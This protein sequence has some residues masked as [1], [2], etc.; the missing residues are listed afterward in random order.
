MGFHDIRQTFHGVGLTWD[1]AGESRGKSRGKHG[2]PWHL[3]EP[4]GTFDGITP[5]TQQNK[6]CVC[7]LCGIR[8][9]VH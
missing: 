4:H 2:T 7:V 6:K 3:T 5:I 1:A 8:F 9:Q